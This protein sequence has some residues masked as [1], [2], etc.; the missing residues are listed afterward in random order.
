MATSDISNVALEVT[1]T[2]TNQHVH[3]TS[4]VAL[5]EGLSSKV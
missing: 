1:K 2:L 4:M 5:A 3:L